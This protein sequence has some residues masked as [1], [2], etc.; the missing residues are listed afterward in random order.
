MRALVKAGPSVGFELRDVPVP[1]IREDEVLIHVRAAGVC[2][3][4]VHIYEW[5]AGYEA[6]QSAMPV[7]IGHEFAGTI[8]AV[9]AGIDGLKEGTR[10]AVRPSGTEPKIKFYM[11]IRRDPKGARFSAEELAA[12]K[13]ESRASL[14]ALWQWIQSDVKARL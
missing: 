10:V 12:V 5:T 2:G 3:T 13:A 14:D 4:D 11:F 8:A 9:G 1:T 7:T 6:M